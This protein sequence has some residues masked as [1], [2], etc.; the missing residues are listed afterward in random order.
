M[1]DREKGGMPR[2]RGLAKQRNEREDKV[3]GRSAL[4]I[5]FSDR[6]WLWLFVIGDLA[7]LGIAGAFPGWH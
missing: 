4:L 1:A 2:R 6:T 3:A 5:S 7:G